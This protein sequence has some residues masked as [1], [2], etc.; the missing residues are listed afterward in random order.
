MKFLTFCYMHVYLI[1]RFMGPTWGPSGSDR[2]QVGPM[3]ASWTLL[4]EHIYI[5]IIILCIY[6]LLHAFL[7]RT[8]FMCE[9]CGVRDL[10]LQVLFSQLY[11]IFH[12]TSQ[13]FNVVF[14]DLQQFL[15]QLCRTTTPFHAINFSQ[16]MDRHATIYYLDMTQF[17]FQTWKT[18]MVFTHTWK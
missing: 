2:T 3:L 9:T 16:M 11:N 12:I 1:A 4:S 15:I 17:S 5:H 14:A 7:T 10:Y 8:L 18:Y 6:I 13:F